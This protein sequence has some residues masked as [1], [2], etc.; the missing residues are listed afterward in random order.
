MIFYRFIGLSVYR[1]IGLSV[2]RF[3]M[4]ENFEEDVLKMAKLIPS[5]KGL[6]D[7]FSK[8]QG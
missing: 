3:I 7:T 8:C 1:F 5:A 4:Y 2:Y 6:C